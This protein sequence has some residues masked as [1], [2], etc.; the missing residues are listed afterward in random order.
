MVDMAAFNRK[1]DADLDA[2]RKAF[3]GKYASELTELMGLSREE[4][5]AVSPDSTD[6][7]VYDQLITVVKRASQHNLSQAQLVANI[8]QLGKAAV[9]IAKK[10]GRLAGLLA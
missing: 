8:K 2:G 3:E 6:L 4:I 10:S 7:L 9:S 5:E 1:L